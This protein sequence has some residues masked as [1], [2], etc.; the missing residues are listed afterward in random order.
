MVAFFSVENATCFTRNGEFSGCL[1]FKSRK[2]FDFYKKKRIEPKGDMSIELKRKWNRLNLVT[3][4]M[5][6]TAP[7]KSWF[8]EK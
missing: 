4:S 6:F 8:R 7:R 2:Q 3:K 5:S 1:K